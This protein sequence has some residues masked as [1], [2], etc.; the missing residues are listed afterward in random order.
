MSTELFGMEDDTP[1]GMEVVETDKERDARLRK[2][3]IENGANDLRVFYHSNNKTM[4]TE[5]NA[6][7]KKKLKMFYHGYQQCRKEPRA[8]VDRSWTDP[9]KANYD[10]RLVCWWEDKFDDSTPAPFLKC[11]RFDT[12][13]GIGYGCSNFANTLDEMYA[14]FSPHAHVHVELKFQS[15]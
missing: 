12:L 10:R 8:D 15:S 6:W 14:Y 2:E 13:S 5:Y 3:F 9:A 7:H 4:P 11:P 1:T